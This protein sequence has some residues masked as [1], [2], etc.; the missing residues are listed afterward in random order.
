MPHKLFPTTRQKTKIRNVFAK[1]MSRGMKLS[2]AQLSKIVQRS[3][4]LGNMLS[5]LDKKALASVA[6]PFA[7]DTLP[8]LISNVASNAINKFEKRVG[9]K[10]VARAGKDSFYSFQMK[11]CMIL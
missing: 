1:N 10:G 8:G 3:R 4:F 5:D 9:G 11:T 6:V 2:K 7:K